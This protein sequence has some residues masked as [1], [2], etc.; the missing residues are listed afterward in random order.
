MNFLRENGAIIVLGLTLVLIGLMYY[1]FKTKFDMVAETL[2]KQNNMIQSL[3]EE[4]ITLSK[5]L[6]FKNNNVA[7]GGMPQGVIQAPSQDLAN[8]GPIMEEDSKIKV[9]DD[10]MD[11]SDEELESDSESSEV[12]YTDIEENDEPQIVEV[13]NINNEAEQNEGNLGL[14]VIDVNNVS[15]LTGDFDH[16]EK[17]G[18]ANDDTESPEIDNNEDNSENEDNETEEDE[19]ND[20]N[21]ENNS[22]GEIKIEKSMEKLKKMKV[23]ELRDMAYE[24][25][26]ASKNIIS[27]A[28]KSALISLIFYHN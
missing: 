14:K 22:L 8:M 28:D 15:Q 13:L 24:N 16:V 23:K 5:Q 19:E 26:V 6:N 18:E 2:E 17:I 4:H 21:E 20:E 12:N 25:E 3:A 9:S 11:S 7:F 10:E 1:F 27:S